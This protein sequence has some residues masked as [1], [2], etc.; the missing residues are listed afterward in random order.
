[1]RLLKQASHPLSLSLSPEIIQAPV[2]Q[3]AFL[4]STVVFT[5]TGSAANSE[6]HLIISWRVGGHLISSNDTSFNTTYDRLTP[7]TIRSDLTFTALD[8]YNN[9]SIICT[10]FELNIESNP[11]THTSVDSMPTAFIRLQGIIIIVYC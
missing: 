1:M 11:P 2:S 8:N 10:V 4:N 6:L 9:T 5:C 7:T 3:N